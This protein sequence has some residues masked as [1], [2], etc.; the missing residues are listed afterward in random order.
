MLVGHFL[1]VNGS[2]VAR[3]T[4]FKHPWSRALLKKRCW[5]FTVVHLHCY[6]MQHLQWF[7]VLTIM[8]TWIVLN[9]AFNWVICKGSHFAHSMERNSWE[10]KAYIWNRGILFP[11]SS[12]IIVMWWSSQIN[13]N[14][15]I[16]NFTFKWQK[17]SKRIILTCEHKCCIH[18]IFHTFHLLLRHI[19]MHSLHF[20]DHLIFIHVSHIPFILLSHS[21]NKRT[22]YWKGLLCLD[23][24]WCSCSS[25][26]WTSTSCPSTPQY[27]RKATT[28]SLK[29]TILFHFRVC[30]RE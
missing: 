5:K 9:Y 30:L 28:P 16:I 8:R 2:L 1:S 26:S 23:L 3:G 10:K 20:M 13:Q 14:C 15:G 24:T 4:Q 19:S 21:F 12:I 17:W 29:Y 25:T 6:I 22:S 11:P 7:E 27:T 18:H